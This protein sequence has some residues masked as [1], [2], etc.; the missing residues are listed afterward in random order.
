MTCNA[1]R[2][3]AAAYKAKKIKPGDSVPRFEFRGRR[4]VHFDH[5]TYS[6]RKDQIS[7]YTMEGRVRCPFKL[8]SKQQAML[9]EG[10]AKEA[11]L[12][13]QKGKWYLH[14]VLEFQE[15]PTV[16]SDIAMGVDLGE[17]NLAATSTGKLF[18]GG[19][20]R[21]ARDQLL[22][23]RARLQ[24]NGSRSAK[25]RLQRISGKEK[26]YTRDANHCLSKAIV[27]EAKSIGAGVIVLE[28]LTHLRKRIKAGRALRRRLHRWRWHQLQQL[29]EYKAQSAGIRI[30]YVNPAYTSQT[31]SGC[32]APG[33]R[34]KNRFRCRQCGSQQH[35]DINAS[36]NLCRLVASADA[37]TAAVD[38]PMVAALVSKETTASYKP[39]ALARGR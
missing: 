10:Q 16:K 18:K 8:G 17:K 26:R 7:L 15:T 11:E 38:P 37:A 39:L 13:H 22:A 25:R 14:L 34:E 36:K 3:V 31:C 2:K 4:S 9:A 24:S 21:H 12:I 1:I 23:K 20:L 6:I 32:G 5:R 28:E 19:E 29:I 30:A 33:D 27:E 35:A